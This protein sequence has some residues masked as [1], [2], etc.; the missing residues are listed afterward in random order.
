M[1][2]KKKKVKPEKKVELKVWSAR[3]ANVFISNFY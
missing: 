2:K 3:F 1:L